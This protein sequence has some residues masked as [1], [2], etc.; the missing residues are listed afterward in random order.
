MFEL[1]ISIMGPG[2]ERIMILIDFE[3]FGM[4]CL[5]YA[6]LKQAINILQNNY[7][8]RLGRVCLLDPPFVFRA[9]WA[10][11][12]PWLD[13]RTRQKVQF[14]SGDYRKELLTM[15]D[16]AALP[17][18]YG[19]TSD[20]VYAPADDAAAAHPYGLL[21]PPPAAPTPAAAAALA[22]A[23]APAP[24]ALA[25]SAPQPAPSATAEP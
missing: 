22:P 18:K 8:E 13:E 10:V 17:A 11:I 15:V 2:V 24:A 25:S 23:A 16:A 5:D 14:L 6:F 20:F 12:R 21:P 19:G 7:P 9:A 3:G 1:A 4:H